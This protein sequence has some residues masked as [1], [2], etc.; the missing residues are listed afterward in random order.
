MMEYTPVIS[1]IVAMAIIVHLFAENTA[2]KIITSD[3][4]LIDGGAAMFSAH[5][6]NHAAMAVGINAIL[7]FSISVLREFLF[8]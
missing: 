2:L 4:K 5:P 7:P 6:M 3:R 1:A 8:K